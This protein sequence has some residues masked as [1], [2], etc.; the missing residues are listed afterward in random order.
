MYGW[1]AFFMPPPPH[2]AAAATTRPPRAI[3]AKPRGIGATTAAA[4]PAAPATTPPATRRRDAGHGR[5]RRARDRR[6]D[7]AVRRSCSRIAAAA[8][9]TGASRTTRRRGA[10]GGPGSLERAGDQPRPFSLR[11]DD[12]Q[13]TQRLN[14]S[15]YRV[16]GDTRRARR[17]DDDSRHRSSSSSRTPRAPRAQGVPLRAAEFYRRVLRRRPS[18]GSMP[19]NPTDRSGGPGLGDLGAASAAA[20]SS[21][22]TPS[23]RRRRSSIATATSSAS[24]PTRSR[25]QPV[26]EGQFRFAGIDDHYFLAAPSTRGRRASSTARSRCRSPA[27]TQRQFLGRTLLAS[28]SRH[29]TVRF[30]VGPKQFDLLRRRRCGAGARHRFRHLL[31]DGGAAADALKWLYGFLG[32]YGWAIIVLTILINLVLF[33]PRHRSVV[34]RCGRCRQS[35]RR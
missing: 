8:S 33:P 18:S 24:T 15:L 7:V 30:F 34:S 12:P 21:R 13:I 23:S 31:V 28:R 26:H 27:A 35:S 4:A 25:E 16:S 11:V 9:C 17:C 3:T 14:D 19:L 1:Q 2:H 10:A 29:A 32:N 6:R 22:A 20:A 5:S